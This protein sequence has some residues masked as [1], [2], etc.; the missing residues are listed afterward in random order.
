MSSEVRLPCG[1]AGQHTRFRPTVASLVVD[2]P[3]VIGSG[4][5]EDM[6]FIGPGGIDLLDFI[7]AIRGHPDRRPQFVALDLFPAGNPALGAV[8]ERCRLSVMGG[9]PDA[10]GQAC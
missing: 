3:V 5:D 6:P 9:Y 8:G 10:N 2:G 4:E 1:T 7:D